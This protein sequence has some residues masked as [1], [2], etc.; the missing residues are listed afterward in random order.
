M[1][2]D[3][4]SMRGSSFSLSPKRTIFYV[5]PL[6]AHYRVEVIDALSRLFLVKVFASSGNLEPQGFSREKPECEEFID[7]KITCA[8]PTR[9]KIQSKILDRMVR[10]RPAAVFIF[11]DVT[12]VSLWL[13][14]LA[15]RM[16]AIPTVIHGQGLYRHDPP[17]LLRKLCYRLAIKLSTKYVCYSNASR[18]S[19]QEI[20]CSDAK[21]V[22]ARNSLF[23]EQTVHPDRKS[24][25]E[26]GVLFIGRLRPACNIDKLILAV[27]TARASGHAIQLH[28]IGDGEFGEL[29]RERYADCSFVQWHGAVFDERL[30]AEISERCRIGCYPGAAGLSVVHMFGLSLPPLVHSSLAKHMGPEPEYVAESRTGFLYS[31]E[32]G[33]SA[34]AAALIRIWSMPPVKIRRIARAAFASYRRLNSPTLGDQLACVVQ[35]AISA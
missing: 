2:S 10:E 16:L 24:G 17:G 32:G 26:T 20:G 21:L 13:S 18:R 31:Y 4:T 12:Y 11:A 1:D 14:L 7:T 3:F 28:V 35:D 27:K 25:L 30:I 5:Q 34:L 6:I 29:M 15:G 23:L 19:L 8:L 9:V 22:V 33:E